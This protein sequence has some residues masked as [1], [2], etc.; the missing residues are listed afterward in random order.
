MGASITSLCLALRV[1]QSPGALRQSGS[2][3]A[4]P[5]GWRGARVPRS[6]PS[7]P[8]D[9]PV[10]LQGDKHYAQMKARLQEVMQENE[11][12]P[13]GLG[14]NGWVPTGPGVGRLG[15]GCSG[16]RASDPSFSQVLHQVTK[17]LE[18]ALE[19]EETWRVGPLAPHGCPGGPSAAPRVMGLPMLLPGHGGVGGN[20]QHAV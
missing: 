2:E 16:L 1:A 10:V 12:V 11:V 7:R 6:Q 15:E 20:V 8:H 17:K 5:W 19:Q 13:K 4:W 14:E 3:W 18:E 9:T